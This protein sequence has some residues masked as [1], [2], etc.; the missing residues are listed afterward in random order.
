M[1]T[2][3]PAPRKS[4]ARAVWITLASLGGALVVFFIGMGTGAAGSDPTDTAATRPATVTVTATES[5]TATVTVRA[6]SHHHRSANPATHTPRPTATHQH[7]ER[8]TPT[9]TKTRT[10]A[11]VQHG[12]HPGAFCSP[13]GALGYTDKG[14]LMHCSTKPGD[15]YWRWRSAG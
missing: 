5:V 8:P 10:S 14:T 13:H 6:N 12:V 4:S 1:T 7:T 15:P 3:R 11:P 9:R 2:G